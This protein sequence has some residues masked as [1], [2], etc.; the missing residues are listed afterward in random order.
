MRIFR[1]VV[2][3]SDEWFSL[4][5]G[6]PTA[7][8]FSRIISPGGKESKS[9]D[10]YI[11]E[12]ITEMV[13]PGSVK[14]DFYSKH[15]EHGRECEPIARSWYSFERDIDVEEVGFC[16]SDCGRFGCSPDGLIGED[17][18]LEIKCPMLK[19]HISW[20]RRGVLPDDHKCQVHGELLVTGREWIDFVS[21][22][23]SVDVPHLVVRVYPSDF[24]KKLA[25]ELESFLAKLAMAKAAVFSQAE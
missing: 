11:D 12:L 3:R 19:T 25:D 15:V 18:G 14:S 17:G 1:D 24:T 22:S 20:L 21:Y 2:Q 16:L 8:E 7:S 6:R 5:R 13:D 4:R 23:P 9:Q 10:G